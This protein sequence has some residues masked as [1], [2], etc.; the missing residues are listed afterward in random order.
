V[1][2]A[3][4][5]RAMKKKDIARVARAYLDASKFT[6]VVVGDTTQ[7]RAQ[8]QAD[9]FSIGALSP[10]RVIVP[11]QIMSIG[12]GAAHGKKTK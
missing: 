3:R 12:T 5:I 2:Y 1:E 11:D 10:A 7:L 6:Y 9:G 8:P 4:K